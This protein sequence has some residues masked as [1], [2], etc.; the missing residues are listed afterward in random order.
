MPPDRS[1]ILIVDDVPDNIQV[2]HE[3]LHD[4]YDTYFATS[5]NEALGTFVTVRPDLVLL[6]IMMPG[7]DGYEVCRA[8]KEDEATKDTPVIFVTALGQA[9]QETRGLEMGA[10]DYITKPFNPSLV[11]LRVKNHL[12]LKMQR[13]TL[14]RRTAELER[15]LAKVKT[16]TGLLPICGGCKKIRDDTGYWHQLEEYIREHSQAEFTHSLCKS[17]AKELYP[18]FYCDI[19]PEDEE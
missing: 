14:A 3:V 5:G 9:H 16:L 2:L 19:F 18:E 10:A 7:I 11:R 13:D 8:L 15:A 4:D 1:R 12:E 17:C 6:D